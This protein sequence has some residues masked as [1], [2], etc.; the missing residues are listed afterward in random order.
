[1]KNNGEQT[2]TKRYRSYPLKFLMAAVL[3]LIC[4]NA[5]AQETMQSAGKPKNWNS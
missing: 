3:F 1:M 4:F 5:Y 2:T